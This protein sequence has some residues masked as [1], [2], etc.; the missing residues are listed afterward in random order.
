VLSRWASERGVPR[1][2]SDNQIVEVPL[3]KTAAAVGG[4]KVFFAAVD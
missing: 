2:S 1:T 3:S 4:R